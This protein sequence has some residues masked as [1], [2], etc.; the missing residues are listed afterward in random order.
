MPHPMVRAAPMPEDN[1]INNAPRFHRK[2]TKVIGVP[3]SDLRP[4][5]L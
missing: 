3:T 4:G 2:R 1:F 5:I